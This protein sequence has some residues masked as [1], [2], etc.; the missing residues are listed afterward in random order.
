MLK[1]L[2]HKQLSEIFRAYLYD[3]KK[4]KTR[5]KGATAAYIVLF[6]LIM[7][8]MLGGMFTY[9]SLSICEP[10]S[11]AGMDW[12]YFALMGLIAILLGSFGSVF[13]TYSGLYL[14]K[15]NDLLLS[16]PIPVGVIM[17]ARLLVVYIMGLLYSG[18]VI[19]PAAA[20]YLIKVSATVG[21][22]IGSFMSVLH[23]GVCS[24]AVVHPRMGSG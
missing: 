7:A 1:L 21:S 24:N 8:G 3:A 11:A 5:S 2:I 15:D 16:M 19:I 23:L 10:L 22:V 20:V 14:A 6:V 18:V 12:L 13:N 9:L 17:T 4:N